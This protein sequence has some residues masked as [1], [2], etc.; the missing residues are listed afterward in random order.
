MHA[1]APA[2]PSDDHQTI[3]IDGEPSAD[4]TI[5]LIAGQS[6]SLRIASATDR[7]YGSAGTDER[8]ATNAIADSR[9]GNEG[10]RDFRI[11]AHVAMKT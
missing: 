8:S 4:G 1:I 2:D 9:H 6:F 5:P 10:M 11:V 7:C 3:A